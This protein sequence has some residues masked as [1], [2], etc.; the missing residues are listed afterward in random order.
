MQVNPWVSLGHPGVSHVPRW[1]SRSSFCPFPPFRYCGKIFPRSANLTRHLRTH[2]GEQPY[3][4]QLHFNGSFL[5]D[6]AM[7]LQPNW[8]SA[9][10][11]GVNTAIAPSASRPTFSVTFATSTTRR[12]PSSVTCATAALVS[13]PT[14]TAI[15]RSTSMRTFPVSSPASATPIP[16][17][18]VERA[19]L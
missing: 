4:Y 19:E 3:R 6:L 8:R 10:L 5:A 9:P 17:R 15:S 13:R 7:T 11:P 16:M 18:N 12:S 2:T 14:S 1:V